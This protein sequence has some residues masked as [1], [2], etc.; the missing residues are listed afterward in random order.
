MTSGALRKISIATLGI[1]AILAL[2]AFR[3]TREVAQPAP[4]QETAR[5]AVLQRIIVAA[6][7]VEAGA[8][9]HPQDV[10]LR[11]VA[12]VPA[13]AFDRVEQV[14]DRTIAV[15]IAAGGP[16]L[17]EHF[18]SGAALRGDL[19]AGERA[20]A[21]KTDGVVGLGGFVEPGDHVDVLVY[22]QHDG[23]EI[24]TSQGRVL[25]RDIRVLAYGART[26]RT[27][28]EREPAEART[29]VLAVRDDQVPA[30]ML[31]AHKGQLR[32]ALR[33]ETTGTEREPDDAVA[34]LEDLLGST[35]SA[36]PIDRHR[37]VVYRG[38]ERQELTP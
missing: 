6:G 25:L 14:A 16:I 1:A 19:L 36:S 22:L 30:L 8:V 24:E 12:E 32:L 5:P 37:V 31:G 34:T 33:A 9:L 4:E 3:M 28:P 2:L 11:E 20:L 18:S 7:P 35:S 29:A 17:A 38:T 15:A 27:T 26:L 13:G 23:R 21:V 10:E